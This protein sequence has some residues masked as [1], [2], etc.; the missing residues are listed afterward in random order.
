MMSMSIRASYISRLGCCMGQ[1]LENDDSMCNWCS[2][3]YQYWLSVW[4][5]ILCMLFEFEALVAK[6]LKLTFI[7]EY[8]RHTGG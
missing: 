5:S 2:L 4:L 8:L 3:F 7:E 6:V 1:K